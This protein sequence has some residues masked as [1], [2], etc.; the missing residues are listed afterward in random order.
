[1]KRIFSWCS[2]A[3]EDES[4]TDHPPI[5]RRRRLDPVIKEA[6]QAELDRVR[7]HVREKQLA[8]RIVSTPLDFA[9]SDAVVM[10]LIN[11]AKGDLVPPL[12]LYEPHLLKRIE[13]KQ[14]PSVHELHHIMYGLKNVMFAGFVNRPEDRIYLFP[15]HVEDPPTQAF[16]TATCLHLAKCFPEISCVEQLF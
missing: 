1:M 2:C 4:E 12:R 10:E 3:Q 14:F 9:V 7:R 5:K 15:Y 11:I 8:L 16:V 6:R 13:K